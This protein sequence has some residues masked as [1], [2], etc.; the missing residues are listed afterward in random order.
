[1][2][3]R[4]STSP[5]GKRV[6]CAV[7]SQPPKK[8]HIRTYRGRN[9]AVA[10]RRVVEQTGG[11]GASAVG[12]ARLV[13]SI[14]TPVSAP[15]PGGP[16]FAAN[17]G[18]RSLKRQAAN[19]PVRGRIAKSA[20]RAR[21]KTKTTIVKRRRQANDAPTTTTTAAAAAATAAAPAL[22]SLEPER[23]ID[24]RPVSF[25]VTNTRLTQQ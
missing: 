1:M 10:Y 8:K 4:V 7:P 14:I 17:T 22:R 6:V 19:K 21:P 11:V 5:D 20:A 16:G 3:L 13:V 23:Q 2:S 24:F 18:V 12:D 25:L 15:A 9:L